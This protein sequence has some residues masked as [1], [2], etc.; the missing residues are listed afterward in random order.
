MTRSVSSL[1]PHPIIYL[2]MAVHS[3]DHEARW[4]IISGGWSRVIWVVYYWLWIM[5][6]STRKGGVSWWCS[7]ID[8]DLHFEAVTRYSLK[9]LWATKGRI[10]TYT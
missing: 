10:T 4:R 9:S 5:S 6:L 3:P 2:T 1:P 8:D 7:G